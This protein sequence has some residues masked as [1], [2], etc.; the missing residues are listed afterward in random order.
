MCLGNEKRCVFAS[1][2]NRIYSE[3]P[4]PPFPPSP[5]TP[6][7]ERSPKLFG[8]YT[9]S[10]LCLIRKAWPMGVYFTAKYC[11]LILLPSQLNKKIR[12]F[13]NWTAGKDCQDVETEIS[14]F[15]LYMTICSR[16]SWWYY[17]ATHLLAYF[18]TNSLAD[19][20]P[21]LTQTKYV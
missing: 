14:I 3:K 2:F 11:Q 21:I 12:I 8:R 18:P 1:S 13:I 6:C 4:P 20:S 10:Q 17:T 15:F 9:P 7:I 5:L 19:F 16:L